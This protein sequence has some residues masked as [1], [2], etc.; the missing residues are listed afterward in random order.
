MHPDYFIPMSSMFILFF[1]FRKMAI[2]YDFTVKRLDD[3]K[4]LIFSYDNTQ[5]IDILEDAIS[6]N[7]FDLFTY[8]TA[9]YQDSNK[10]ALFEDL[11]QKK[12]YNPSK[13]DILITRFYPKS[14]PTMYTFE[15]HHDKS[16]I[17]IFISNVFDYKPTEEIDVV[18]WHMNFANCD[19][20]AYYHSSLLA[21]D[22]LQVLEC[23]QL[24]SLREYLVQQNKYQALNIKKFNTNVVENNLPYPILISNVERVVDLNTTNLYGK[25]FDDLNT[26]QLNN[27]FFDDR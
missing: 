2:P 14:L 12:K 16:K 9:K 27:F 8:F 15:Q 22:E 24:A 21:Q 20:F 1:I 3:L 7:G 11:L 10:K 23:P 25:K 5:S 18:E 4:H 6:M 26:L 13:Q 19:I 17:Y